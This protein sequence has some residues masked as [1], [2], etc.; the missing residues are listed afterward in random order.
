MIQ[1]EMKKLLTSKQKLLRKQK[2]LTDTSHC[3]KVYV[4]LFEQPWQVTPTSNQ[5]QE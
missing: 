2:L 4:V 5:V 3:Y 1:A